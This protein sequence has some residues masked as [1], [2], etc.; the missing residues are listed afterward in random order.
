VAF[1]IFNARQA[2]RRRIIAALVALVV[3]VAGALLLGCRTQ[4]Q[5]LLVDYDPAADFSRYHTF[6]FVMVPATYKLG[7]PSFVTRQI[8]AAVT[9]EMGKRGYRSDSHSADLLVNFSGILGKGRGAESTTD[10]YAYR[11]YGAWPAY[12]RSEHMPA[13][14]YADGTLNIDLIDAAS[15]QLVWEGV[16]I[17][18]VTSRDA[19]AQQE[20]ITAAVAHVFAKFPFRAG[21][22][23]SERR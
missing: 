6:K 13:G 12:Q 20:Q 5:H 2:H 11:Y 1:L 9:D 21:Q 17:G 8:A 23:N 18:E 3:M 10:Y 4:Q 22:Q 14:E 16:A 19:P 7:Y 15:M